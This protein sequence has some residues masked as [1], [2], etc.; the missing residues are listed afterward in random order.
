MAKGKFGDGYKE[1]QR[2]IIVKE[3]TKAYLVSHYNLEKPEWFPK[4][5]CEY[6][7]RTK[8]L[9]ISKWLA[10]NKNID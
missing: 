8:S 6:S 2:A 4:S 1:L 3:T 7:K 10:D 5:Q 9:V